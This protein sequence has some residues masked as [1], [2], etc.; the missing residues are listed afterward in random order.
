MYMKRRT[1]GGCLHFVPRTIETSIKTGRKQIEARLIPSQ[2]GYKAAGILS[3]D[4]EVSIINEHQ[5]APSIDPVD[6]LYHGF[7][8]LS[9]YGGRA[10]AM[11]RDGHRPIKLIGDPKLQAEMREEFEV[12][13]FASMSWILRLARCLLDFFV[14]VLDRIR[15][16]T[17]PIAGRSDAKA[18]VGVSP[19]LICGD[20]FA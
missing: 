2:E 6:G 14:R 20:I 8:L 4:E 19:A 9:C 13:L 7:S 18:S 11:Y 1:S 16:L 17:S 10:S 5:L 3:P 12:R 15:L